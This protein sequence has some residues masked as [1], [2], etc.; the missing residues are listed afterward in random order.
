MTKQY[1]V[2]LLHGMFGFGQQQ[3]TNNVLPYFGIWNTDIRRM[4]NDMGVP[5]VAPS[6]GPFT[7]AWNRACEVYAQLF[8]G[9]VDYGKAHAERYGMER[10]GATYDT[11]LLPQWGTLDEDGDLIKINIIGHSFG[12]VSGRML[13]EL[14]A[15]GCEAERAATDPDDLSDLFKGGHKGWVHSITTLASPHNGMTSVEGKVGVAMKHIC[16]GICDVMNVLDVTPKHAIYDLSLG[17]YGLTPKVGDYKNVWKDKEYKSYMFDNKDTIVYDLTIKGA[18]E[19]NDCLPTQDDIYYFSYRGCRTFH[20]PVLGYEVP[21][22][23]SFPLLNVLGFFMGRQGD[24][25]CPTREWRKN[26]MVINTSSAECPDGAPRRDVTFG[27][28]TST[29][30]PGIWHVYPCELKDHMSYLG[31]VEPKDEFVDFYKTIYKTV[32]GL[33]VV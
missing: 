33:P 17:M 3:T 18:H 30:K 7:S 5:C 23:K 12:G 26:D 1:P 32:S 14:M 20:V 25:V 15:N 24:D 31:W 10:Y 27:F 2:V 29:C 22:L 28:D 16:R 11:P 13:A 6:M 8:G 4:F 19:A 9:T 21:R